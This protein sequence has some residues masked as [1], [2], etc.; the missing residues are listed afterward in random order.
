MEKATARGYRLTFEDWL[1][2]P[3]DGQ[4]YEI[5]D[6]ELF[7]SPSPSVKHQR[8]VRSLLVLLD[9]F[10]RAG[11][12]GEVLPA[13]IG[14]KL[15]EDTVPQPDLLVVLDEN[16]QRVGT[17]AVHGLPDVVVEVLSP[18][19]AARDLGVKRDRYELAGIPEY[20]I[21][22]SESELVEVL[23]LESGKYTLWGRFGLNDVLTSRVLAGLRIPLR[24][25]FPPVR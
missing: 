9:R 20:W 13:P 19:T 11:S 18:G 23:A 22:D 10:L 4:R 6:G 8:I 15:A 12:L 25:V 5:I 1:K 7:V 16:Q 3:E 14:V 24:E 2:F 21:V 17:Q